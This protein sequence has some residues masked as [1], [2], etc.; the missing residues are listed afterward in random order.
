MKPDSCRMRMRTSPRKA[1]TGVE[2]RV[3]RVKKKRMTLLQLRPKWVWAAGALTI[4]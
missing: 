2:T 4:S 3:T 1:A